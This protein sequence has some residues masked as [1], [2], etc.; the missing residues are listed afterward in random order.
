MTGEGSSGRS[1]KSALRKKRKIY[2][3]DS[4]DDENEM[5]AFD[6]QCNKNL[7]NTKENIVETISLSS[8]SDVDG[9]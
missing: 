2:Y 6:Q 1:R 9:K 8:E 7:D 5:K 4:T 3:Q